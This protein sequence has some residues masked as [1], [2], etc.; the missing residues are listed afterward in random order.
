MVIGIDISQIVYE[1]TGVSNFVKSL[2]KEVIFQ[3]NHRFVL[4]ASTYRFQDRIKQFYLSLQGAHDRVTLVLVPVPI[5]VFEILWN[6]LHVVPVEWIIGKVDVFWSSD[7]IQP[8][9]YHAQ[10]VTTIHDLTPQLYPETFSKIIVQ[11]HT[12]KLKRSVGTCQAFF[13]DSLATKH[14]A[15]RLLKIPMER[16]H[17][18]Y[19]GSGK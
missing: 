14:D 3:S 5:W 15:A 12:R 1:G 9:L 13:C 6:R 10:G 2:V 4:F 8:P 18:I 11:T 16:I 17:V 7:W 19:A